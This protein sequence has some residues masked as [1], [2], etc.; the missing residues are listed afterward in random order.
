[1]AGNCTLYMYINKSHGSVVHRCN[2]VETG[3][4]RATPELWPQVGG[5]EVRGPSSVAVPANVPGITAVAVS[6]GE[7][8]S[9]AGRGRS[10]SLGRWRLEL[11][12]RLG[13]EKTGASTVF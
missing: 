3:L 13:K 8:D 10:S 2:I 12:L 6:A 5:E 9:V 7:A 1:M 4:H 11:E